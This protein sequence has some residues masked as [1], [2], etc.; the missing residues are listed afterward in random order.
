MEWNGW[1]SFVEVKFTGQSDAT[2]VPAEWI[3]QRTLKAYRCAPEACLDDWTCREG[4]YGRVCGLCSESYVMST[5]G[6]TKCSL[7][8][9]SLHAFMA[10]FSITLVLIWYLTSWRP[11]LQWF[12]V[13]ENQ[14]GAFMIMLVAKLTGVLSY[15]LSVLTMRAKSKDEIKKML[16]NTFR[17]NFQINYMVGYIKTV[18]TFYQVTASFLENFGIEWPDLIE[19]VL[20]FM[21]FFTFDLFNFP[22]IA[23][24]F[25]DFSYTTKHQIF[26]LVPI[27]VVFLLMVPALL[28]KTQSRWK[29][30]PFKASVVDDVVGSFFFWMLSFLFFIYPSV[31][32]T[33]LNT[34]NC[35]DLG[36]HGSWLKADMRVEC[37][38]HT[39]DFG[40]EFTSSQ[41]YLDRTVLCYNM[42]DISR[43]HICL[44]A[45]TCGL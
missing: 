7:N 17:L 11:L 13:Q 16:K 18:V 5:D 26:T 22:S 2:R 45:G 31:S 33:V 43:F 39:K 36:H 6:C 3:V 10:L 24:I 8:S 35:L 23:C 9:V 4:H 14:F 21:N 1:D 19:R 34:F 38:S 30:V 20:I 27:G 28:V 15:L 44:Y 37:P 40:Y 42:H 41:D 12:R 29:R 32:S 25:K